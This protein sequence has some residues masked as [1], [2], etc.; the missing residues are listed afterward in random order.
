MAFHRTMQL[1]VLGAVLALAAAPTTANAEATVYSTY[2][3]WSPVAGAVTEVTALCSSALSGTSCA[4]PPTYGN[5]VSPTFLP[6]SNKL[7]NITPTQGS[8]LTQPL[9]YR[10]CAP[11]S[12]PSA[13]STNSAVWPAFWPN[14]VVTN[15]T[16]AGDVWYS[17]ENVPACDG[18]CTSVLGLTLSLK[19]GLQSFGFDVLPE[20]QPTTSSLYDVTVSLND[21]ASM[22][23]A[24]KY[25]GSGA[26]SCSIVASGTTNTGTPN[27]ATANCG[28]FGYTGG[29]ADTTITVTL[30]NGGTS[31]LNG[32]LGIGDF[33]FGAAA[34][35]EPASLALLGV[36]LVGLGAIRRRRH[37]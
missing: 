13:C 9:L 3:S 29:T 10:G 31:D 20:F 23:E 36:G 8:P 4:S 34:A 5:A 33:V 35:P 12:P 7:T 22:E 16:Y 18:T 37:A 27:P 14:D 11:S 30:A 19:T 15:T 6:S 32:G 26:E 25:S 21:G 17:N 24:I 2:S 1:G 28:F